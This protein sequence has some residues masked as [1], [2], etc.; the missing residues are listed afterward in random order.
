[1]PPLTDVALV[2][3]YFHP[4]TDRSPFRFPPLGLGYIAS[5]LR[6]HGFS[7][8]LVDCTFDSE[9]HAIQRVRNLSP[10]IVG[11]YSMFSM[12]A[13]ALRLAKLL[14]NNCDLLV[15]GGPLPTLYPE[16]YLKT[17]DVVCIGEGEETMLEIAQALLA[18]GELT[19]VRGICMERN[20]NSEVPSESIQRT[21]PRSPIRDLDLIPFP[22]R[23]LFDN[24]SYKQ[25]FLGRFS[26]KEAS[27][28]TTRGCPFDCDFC[29]QPIFANQFRARSARN[30]VDELTEI[31]SLGYD[32]AWFADD[33]FTLIPKRV[34]E[35]CREIKGRGLDL[36]WECLSRADVFDL[37]MASEMKAAGCER[38][39]F[40]IESGDER[41][42]Q[43]MKKRLDVDQARDAVGVAVK[44]G[45]K[46]GAFFILGYPGEDDTTMLRTIKF[47]SKLP[48][49]Y[50]SFSLPYPIPGTGLYE[51]VKERLREQDW[52]SSP[53]R[54]IDHRLV[55][56]SEFSEFKLKF[57]IAKATLQHHLWRH[58]GKWGYAL[59]GTPFEAVTD[60]VFRTLH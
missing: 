43:T 22:A 19:Q 28:I 36:R 27:I 49:D 23:D 32:W 51:K 57:G 20:T 37:E 12:N 14:R 17:F 10:S 6:N 42:L 11:I 40:G 53:W 29:S 34:F 9:E 21:S 48:L 46:A 2:Y 30:V 26:R 31:S 47:A 38:V 44:A 41:I 54:L 33:C 35:I 45:L 16:D 4:P 60:R 25:Y 13:A 8:E 5:N 58:G 59:L 15:A 3:P 50:V 1:M 7:V 56:D 52:R 55:Y 18:N 24:E 39:F